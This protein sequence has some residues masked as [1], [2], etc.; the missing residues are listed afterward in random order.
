M[1]LFWFFSVLL[2]LFF[3]KKKIEKT[4]KYKKQCMYVDIGTCVPW[5]VIETKFLNFVSL[6]A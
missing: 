5:M 6:V 2:H 4:E 3:K 1:F